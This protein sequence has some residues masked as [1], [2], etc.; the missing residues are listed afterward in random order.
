[1][2]GAGAAG[3]AT[4]ATA[5]PNP[6]GAP[7]IT[8][9]PAIAP[10][11]PSFPFASA[12]ASAAVNGGESGR[13][14]VAL[15]AERMRAR[16]RSSVPSTVPEREPSMSTVPAGSTTMVPH[17]RATSPA[18]TRAYPGSRASS[19]ASTVNAGYHE[20][21]GR[22]ELQLAAT[23]VMTAGS[24]GSAHSTG[25]ARSASM[26]TISPPGSLPLRPQEFDIATHESVFASK[27]ARFDPR[28]RSPHGRKA[29]APDSSGGPGLHSGGAPKGLFVRRRPYSAPVL[30]IREEGEYDPEENYGRLT[31][32]KPYFEPPP[33]KKARVRAGS[34]AGSAAAAAAVSSASGSGGGGGGS[35]A[36]SSGGGGSSAA[37]RGRS[38][39]K[40]TPHGGMLATT[41]RVKPGK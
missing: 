31:K 21:A 17:G 41:W 16:T 1:V 23:P 19:L 29:N 13:G 4:T 37:M 39:T 18:P 12:A 35:A 40:S 10:A 30:P 33:F 24:A 32:K 8:P 38:A 5:T 7:A 6:A 28:S 9:T 14:S 26:R 27:P 3:G 36:S 25:P 11:A 22:A 20:L 34:R 15:L 2:A